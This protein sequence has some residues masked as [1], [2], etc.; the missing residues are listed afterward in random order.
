MLSAF[1][2]DQVAK[3]LVGASCAAREIHGDGSKWV[4]M[5]AACLL[6]EL[7]SFGGPCEQQRVLRDLITTWSLMSESFRSW[8]EKHSFD[9]G[10]SALFASS[11]PANRFPGNGALLGTL[12][13]FFN[14]CFGKRW[15]KSPDD[16]VKTLR[17]RFSSIFLQ[18]TGSTLASSEYVRGFVF[19]VNRRSLATHSTRLEQRTV[20]AVIVLGSD[21][22]SQPGVVECVLSDVVDEHSSK[23]TLFL[24]Y[25]QTRQI[26][27]IFS[28]RAFS[29]GDHA[30]AKHL[31]IELFDAL[32][33]Q[34]VDDFMS[35]HKLR[36]VLIDES[37]DDEVIAEAKV[38]QFR[39]GNE[40]C[41]KVEVAGQN[42]DFNMH[43]FIVHGIDRMA[44]EE[45]G[46]RLKGALTQVLSSRTRQI[47]SH[48]FFELAL[49]VWMQDESAKLCD[50]LLKPVM[51]YL[52]K[53]L[54][55]RNV[56]WKYACT[57]Y[58]SFRL[59]AMEAIRKRLGLKDFFCGVEA[60]SFKFG[61]LQHV[62]ETCKAIVRIDSCLR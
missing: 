32:E 28:T 9:D 17:E 11:L 22:D 50:K 54:F 53:L 38:C 45:A 36:P 48:G 34:V 26:N 16:C 13:L 19:K 43:S 18:V 10:P 61:L 58:V 52:V 27:V 1:D 44:C 21:D 7:S 57:R 41:I 4:V 14:A 2:W 35:I 15:T 25:C 40:P 8:L 39:L 62:L 49:T 51:D 33:K 29:D 20:R 31:C 55:D 59:G 24:C 47:P 6:R 3:P 23:T 46:L 56:G 30:R 12:E 42:F 5:A 37:F 60:L